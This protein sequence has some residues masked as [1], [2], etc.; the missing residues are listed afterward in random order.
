MEKPKKNIMCGFIHYELVEFEKR[1]AIPA[2]MC[3]VGGELA[4]MASMACQRGWVGLCEWSASVY[5]VGGVGS[6]LTWA[7]CYC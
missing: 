2:S 1:C 3:G 6:V 5:S 4:W 7:A